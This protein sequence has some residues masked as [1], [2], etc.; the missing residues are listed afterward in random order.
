MPRRFDH[1]DAYERGHK[2]QFSLRALLRWVMAWSM[3]CGMLGLLGLDAA[4]FALV[5]G[6]GA[7][8]GTA[9]LSL[10]ARPAIFLS[11]LAGA[12]GAGVYACFFAS[13]YGPFA[14]SSAQRVLPSL[15]LGG[16]MGAIGLVYVDFVLLAAYA[17]DVCLCR[18]WQGKGGTHRQK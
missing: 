11:T 18:L 17:A 4:S 14:L 15:L 3:F 1:P 2:F 16:V 13:P 6:W 9:R 10:G 7:L 5:A 12:T 8:V